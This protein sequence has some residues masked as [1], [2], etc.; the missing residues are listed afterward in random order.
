[1]KKMV[2]VFSVLML[3]CMAMNSMASP[4]QGSWKPKWKVRIAFY[5][6]FRTHKSACLE[7]FGLCFGYNLM[8]MRDGIPQK[9]GYVPI[10]VGI[11]DDRSKIYLVVNSEAIQKFENGR[12]LSRFKNVDEVVFDENIQLPEDVLSYF[13]IEK[14]AVFPNRCPIK[15]VDGEYIL[16]IDLK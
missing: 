7:G 13:G 12:F 6:A 5:S 3:V 2:K 16:E 15:V 4:N 14:S 11:N 9:E 1:M 8:I 10:G